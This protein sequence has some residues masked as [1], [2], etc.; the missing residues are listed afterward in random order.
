MGVKQFIWK[1]F[2]IDLQNNWTNLFVTKVFPTWKYL[3][4]YVSLFCCEEKVLQNSHSFI[5]FYTYSA[6]PSGGHILTINQAEIQ[7]PS[8]KKRYVHHIFAQNEKINRNVD[9]DFHK[10][11]WHCYALFFSGHPVYIL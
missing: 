2:T 4:T 8:L 1:A 9:F 10:G 11:Y 6:A 3:P 5:M 7:P